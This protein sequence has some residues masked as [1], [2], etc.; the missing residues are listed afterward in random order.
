MDHLERARE[1]LSRAS[2]SAGGVVQKQVNSVR[3]GV[4]EEGE[5]DKTEEG[6]VKVDRIVEM[7]AKLEGLEEEAEK[8]TTGD[9]IADAREHLRTYVREHPDDESDRL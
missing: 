8:E 2:D 4:L 5:G 1:Q 7:I 6:P 3:E 9:R